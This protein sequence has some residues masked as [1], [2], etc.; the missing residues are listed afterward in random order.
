MASVDPSIILHPNDLSAVPS[1]LAAIQTHSTPLLS[2]SPS[3]A[4]IED[5][6]LSLLQSA[7]A[8]VLALEKPRETMIRHCWADNTAFS[9]LSLG[10]STNIW[11]ALASSPSPQSVPEIASK[12]TSPTLDPDLLSRL[13]KHVAAMG[14]IHETSH[15]TYAPTNFIRSL[16]IP[17]IGDGYR[18]FTGPGTTGGLER[19]VL[20][21]PSYLERNGFQTPQGIADGPLQ[22]AHETKL[23]MFEWLHANPPAGE[24]FNHHMGG[25]ANGRPS[26]YEEGFYPV[27]ERLLGGMEEGG[28]VLVDVGGGL[29]HDLEGF[30][31]V[32]GERVGKGR[33][34][35]QD[36]ERVIS[37]IGEGGGGRVER[38]VYDFYT[39]QPV[40]GARAYYMHS[41]LHDWPDEVC[42]R[43]LDNIKAAMKPGY[44][45][46]LINENVIPDTGAH[47]ETTGLDVMLACLLS[48][49]E[50]TRVEWV[51]LLE[52]KAGLRVVKIYHHRD[53]PRSGVESVV[54]CE[55][56]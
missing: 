26:W 38:M 54:E 4:S 18:I 27:E 23:N 20:S 52:E 47:W 35:L 53:N 45:R 7:R 28:A 46:L 33:L 3:P 19:V 5:A 12:T 41:V 32:W 55:F 8:L 22:Y 25:Y 21:L 42:V 43:I 2:P 13:L 10:I 51:R 56:R 30:D 16:T 37:Q 29:G 31:K 39:E 34:V 24:Q 9:I 48:S 40:K 1:I 6:R 36:L 50:R 14:Y 44:S 49:R 15:N 11:S 17:I